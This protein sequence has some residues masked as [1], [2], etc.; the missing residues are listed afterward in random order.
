MEVPNDDND[1]IIFSWIL[2]YKMD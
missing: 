1:I 2:P